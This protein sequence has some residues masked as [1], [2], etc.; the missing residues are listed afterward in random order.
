MSPT[1]PSVPP[2][3]VSQSEWADLWETHHAWLEGAARRQVHDPALAEEVVQD[4]FI[5]LCQLPRIPDHPAALRTW[6]LRCVWFTAA[7]ARRR[8]RRWRT[9]TGNAENPLAQGESGATGELHDTLEELDYALGR[10]PAT[11]RSLILEHF[12]EGLS[13]EDL[14]R[15]HR[16]SPEAARKRLG[17]ALLAM[18]KHFTRQGRLFPSAVF[19]DSFAD[20]P[21]TS[22]SALTLI[23]SP[24]TGP[25]PFFLMSSTQSAGLTAAV[26]LTLASI[27]L[28]VQHRELI[29]LRAHSDAMSEN[30]AS[31]AGG[32]MEIHAKDSRGT[33]VSNSSQPPASL[34]SAGES[35]GRP[36]VIQSVIEALPRILSSPAG[37]V[38]QALV[39][40]M[41]LILKDPVPSRR[42]AWFG[43]L[44]S[45]LRLN[46]FGAVQG[47]FDQAGREGVL[48]VPELVAFSYQKG[49]LLGRAAVEEVVGEKPVAALDR[50]SGA[51]M[52]GWASRNRQEVYKWLEALPEG[53][54]FKIQSLQPL[55]AS[56]VRE[57]P[58]FALKMVEAS[59]RRNVPAMLRQLAQGEIDR[60]GADGLEAWFH[61]LPDKA[62]WGEA[63][64]DLGFLVAERQSFVSAEA[65]LR[66]LEESSGEPW[67]GVILA[68]R[69]AERFGH[70]N[71]GKVIGILDKLPAGSPLADTL[72]DS[73]F[74][75]M[76]QE[77]RNAAADFLG[78]NPEFV[79]YDR[80]AEAF[81][82]GI[83]DQDPAAARAW[84]G[85]MKDPERRTALLAEL[86]GL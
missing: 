51:L 79:H 28:L 34:Q 59:P 7:N 46:D 21:H 58:D 19:L 61:R 45:L 29:S 86:G 32:R 41:G 24:G 68:R 39:D 15:R 52:E 23:A 42:E 11:A 69:V 16:L 8:N 37:E 84:A 26:C 62:G 40:T 82:R 4:V 57:D 65:G 54:D 18:K 31:S 38:N 77:Q 13:Y 66:V 78:K 35:G 64:A 1:C 75:T 53:L 20:L 22:K 3:Q 6:L 47:L 48:R 80:A 33:D 70:V 5:R 9:E 30:P 81:V 10:L 60:G 83:R 55:F 67:G 85:T 25:H 27:P 72:T 63:R 56:A 14:G 36:G 71:H 73:L 17:R 50:I 76:A 2:P 74:A 44:A 43:A 49:R 12:F